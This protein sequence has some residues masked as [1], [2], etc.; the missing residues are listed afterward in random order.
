MRPALIVLLFAVS[1]LA[2]GSMRNPAQATRTTTDGEIALGN[3]DAEI[4]GLEALVTEDASELDLVARLS[5]RL[6][7][8]GR[9]TGHIA[10]YERIDGLAK[11]MSTKNPHD[12]RGWLLRARADALLHRFTEARRALGEARLRGASALEVAAVAA[13]IDQ[14][15]GNF[16]E[17]RAYRVS[18]QAAESAHELGALAA[19]HGE[20]G[21]LADAERLFE[22]AR[23]AWNRGRDTSPFTIAWLN[24]EEGL[25]W[26]NHDA[27]AKARMRLRE[28]A[29]ILPDYALAQGHL[30]EVEAALGETGS[31]LTRL[32]K[33]TVESDDPDYAHQLARIAGEKGLTAESQHWRKVAERRFR[34]L[35]ERYPEAFA[36]HAAEFWLG[37]GNDRPRA[38]ELASLNASQRHTPRAQELLARAAGH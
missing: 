7:M 33:L 8:R 23:D 18:N 30:A 9:F 26:M 37:I 10:D 25:M 4:A 31:A 5:E 29:R 2:A 1:V 36:D 22:Q 27:P 17:A 3:L 16:A 6:E 34:E 15:T 38:R 21:E 14:A 35:T 13:S 19:I 20:Q 28:A 32:R 12:A 11:A 24:F